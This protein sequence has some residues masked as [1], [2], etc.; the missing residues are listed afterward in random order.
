M[1]HPRAGKRSAL[2]RTCEGDMLL[3]LIIHA[4]DSL[5]LEPRS[6]EEYRKLVE[7]AEEHGQLC[8]TC[9]MAKWSMSCAYLLPFL[10]VFSQQFPQVDCSRLVH[11]SCHEPLHQTGV[12]HC[13]RCSYY[14][15]T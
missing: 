13:R 15:L 3:T 9:L 10:D 12:L 2:Q 1:H 8:V 7:R 5:V 11:T 6:C 4:V 14:W